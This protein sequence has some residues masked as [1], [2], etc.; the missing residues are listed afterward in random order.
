MRYVILV[1]ILCS[2]A[3]GCMNGS[4]PAVTADFSVED[5]ES[6]LWQRSEEEQ[7]IL[8]SSGLLY[9]DEALECYLNQIARRLQPPEILTRIPFKVMVIKSPYLNAFAFPNGVVYVHTGILARMDNEAQLATLLGHEM[10]HCTHRHALKTLRRLKEKSTFPGT[11]QEAEAG[12]GGDADLLTLLGPTG[13]MAAVAGYAQDLETEADTVGLA[14]MSKAGYDP[15][16]ALK[17]FSH[18]KSELEEGK[19][20]EPFFFGTHPR[21]QKRIENYKNLLNSGLS[22]KRSWIKNRETFRSR[23]CPVILDNAFLDLKAGRFSHAQKGAERYL[24][25][26]PAAPRAYFLLGEICR[27]RGGEGSPERAK[28]YYEKALSLDASY[29]DV[30]KAIGVIYYKK[31]EMALAKRAFET[32]MALAPHAP[33]KA[34]IQRYLEH[35]YQ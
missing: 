11:A 12:S 18:L 31:G 7:K 16:E 27:Q 13:S 2:I 17:L 23:V 5:D 32:C 21:L 35:C 24:K 9:R 3:A 20:K 6:R 34:Y 19:V 14:L 8:N 22:E 30:H 10:T 26:E 33:D 28:A 1:V 29:A 25:V 4:L 15:T